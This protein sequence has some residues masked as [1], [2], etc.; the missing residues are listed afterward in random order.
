M[1]KLFLS[2]I[3]LTL[4]LGVSYA[5]LTV[6]VADG[7][8]TNGNVPI[9]GL[10]TD[11]YCRCQTIYPAEMVEE[12]AGRDIE[13]LTWYMSTPASSSLNTTFEIKMGVCNA[14][15]FS[16]SS[17]D[18]S[19][20]MTTVY[21][22]SIP[23][24]SSTQSITFTTPF[25]YTGGNLLIEVCNTVTSNYSSTYW[26][27]VSSSN[28]SRQGHS[29]SSLSSVSPSNYDFIPKTTFSISEGD[30]SCPMPSADAPVVNGMSATV[31][32]TEN[33]TATQYGLWING[34]GPT[35]VNNQTSYTFSDLNP[36]TT[37]SVK[38]RAICAPGDTSYAVTRSFRTPCGTSAL[39]FTD[40][41]E[42]YTAGSNSFPE[43]WTSSSGTNY[44]QASYASSGSHSLHIGGVPAVVVS[45]PLQVNGR[46]VEVIF[47]A[48]AEST[49]SSGTLQVGF[50]TDINNLN[51]V[52]WADVITPSNTYHNEYEFA[53]E[54]SSAVEIGYIVFKQVAVYS[55]YYYWLDDI[56][57]IPMSD[58]RK[59]TNLTVWDVSR[60][61]ASISWEEPVSGQASAYEFSYKSSSETNWHTEIL[62]ERYKFLTG[63]SM[64]TLYEVQVKTV[65]DGETSR[66]VSTTFTTRSCSVAIDGGTTS[67]NYVP[68]YSFYSYGYSQF[69]YLASELEPM[70]TVYGIEFNVAAT[71]N[72]NTTFDVFIANT[73]ATS[74]GTSNYIQSSQLMQV[75]A[76]RQYTFSVGWNYIPFDVPFIY[77]GSSNIVVAFD[78]NTGSYTSGMS[79]VHHAGAGGSCYW[80]RD[81]TDITPSS[82]GGTSGSPSSVPDI[83]F[84]TP[85]SSEECMAPLVL[86]SDIQSHQVTIRWQPQSSESSWTVMYRM[87]SESNWSVAS[88]NVTATDYTLTNL[89]AGITYYFRVKAN[90]DAPLNYSDVSAFTKCD[91]FD[92]TYTENFSTGVINPCWVV[93]GGTTDYPTIFDD[94]FYSGTASGCYAIL[95][96]FVEPLNTLMLTMTSSHASAEGEVIVGVCTNQSIATFQQ[97]ASFPVTS[98][99]TDIEAYF[100]EF[101]G[102]G[103]FIA[104]KLG[105]SYTYIDNI[106]VQLAPSCRKPTNI[107]LEDVTESTATLSWTAGANAIGAT[108][109][110]HRV[111]TTNWSTATTEGNS[112]TLTGLMANAE[113]EVKVS[114]N[115]GDGDNSEYSKTFNFRTNCVD[116]NTVISAA[117]PFI[118][119]FETGLYCWQQE[120]VSGDLE[121]VTQKGDGESNAGAHGIDTAYRG[122]Y[123]ATMYHLLNYASGP[124]TRLISPILNIQN[125]NQP[126]LRYAYG[127]TTYHEY[128]GSNYHDEMTVYYRVGPAAEWVLLREY[129]A[130]TTGWVL[131]SMPL[132][133]ASN[134]YQISFVG[135]FKG[136]NGIALDDVRVYAFGFP[137]GNGEYDD[138]G[139]DDVNGGMSLNIYPNPS[140]G[141]T[142]I[143][144]EGVN[145][146]LT[147]AVVDMNGRTVTSE[148]VECNEGCMKQINVGNLAR[149]AYFVRVFGE[150]VNA[151][152]KLI[153]R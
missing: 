94:Q 113:Y 25:T 77:D 128:T 6:T 95:P 78:N 27:G 53:F 149:G 45:P 99:A 8:T 138:E 82:P 90:C 57:V 79:W 13:G 31:S 93:G 69:L 80:Y 109:K 97:L 71:N 136:G 74:V 19:T 41:F 30:V 47:S 135:Y 100:D 130:T 118:E 85:C 17:F 73:S 9:Y 134:N 63:L 75:V 70:D 12:M 23:C 143:S 141:N 14:A 87:A 15:A 43:C 46:G 72:A 22:G 29:S 88:D 120:F 116:G 129:T 112:I 11:A 108:V 50:A 26:L 60:T 131:D 139:I 48:K 4:G 7:S 142:T 2:L 148:Q 104:I 123:N 92:V 51:N 38:I 133:A 144:I 125:L 33:G 126:Y 10:Y 91:L 55:S 58:C 32:W 24:N 59:P 81:G 122:K 39:P 40:G 110:Y 1:K 35:I 66:E 107:V 34:V 54:N 61:G 140:S 102:N 5:Q 86:I 18:N 64:G 21:T 98:E 37:Y 152:K 150:R 117:K 115:C 127:L 111:G 67:N 96:Q 89:N 153:V 28:A 114:A 42:D 76:N 52:E 103:E 16:G 20:E 56:T 68:F 147:V 49:T 3:A 84:V 121:W 62:T 44:V 105:S 36:M 119:G 106:V 83:H 146:R 132:P 137:G 151:V 145:G 124:K 65:C 101:T